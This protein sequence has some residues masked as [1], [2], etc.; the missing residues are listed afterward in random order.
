MSVSVW[1]FFWVDRGNRVI[2]VNRTNKN[3]GE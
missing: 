2:D 1:Y 3:T